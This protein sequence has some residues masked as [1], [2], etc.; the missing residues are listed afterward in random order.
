LQYL[1]FNLEN[2]RFALPI[3]CV[4]RIVRAAAVTPISNAP[5]HILGVVNVQGRVT[6]V[7]GMRKIYG[8]PDRELDIDD[9]FILVRTGQS[10]LAL[11]VDQVTGVDSGTERELASTDTFAQGPGGL[12]VIA[13]K[14]GELIILHDPERLPDLDEISRLE[15]LLPKER[16]RDASPA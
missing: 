13:D 10:A 9:Q 5:A 2:R 11:V 15:A 3:E 14:E 1:I 4:E 6:P 8:L 12:R 7:I 16:P